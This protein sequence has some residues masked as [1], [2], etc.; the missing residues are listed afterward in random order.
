MLDHYVVRLLPLVLCLGCGIGPRGVHSP[1]GPPRAAPASAASVRNDSLSVA[2]LEQQVETAAATP[3]AAFLDSV[4]A[5]TFRFTHAGGTVQLREELLRRFRQPRQSDAARTLARQVDSLSVEMHQN[6]AVTTGIIHVRQCA[7][8]I[9]RGYAVRFIRVYR[10][11]E[12]NRWQLLSHRTLG[13]TQPEAPSTVG[14]PPA[15][16]CS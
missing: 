10:R 4:W 7:G 8:A 11:S 16:P 9:Y 12:T 15:D 2:A 5:P 13:P 14:A 3:N 6:T 1:S